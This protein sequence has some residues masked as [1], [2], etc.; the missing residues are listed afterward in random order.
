MPKDYKNRAK[1]KGKPKSKS[2][3]LIGLIG[4]VLGAIAVGVLWFN[5][6]NEDYSQEWVGA[7]PDTAPKQKPH[8]AAKPQKSSPQPPKP[9][10]EFYSVLPEMEVVVSDEELAKP[11]EKKQSAIHDNVS[12][13]FVQVA[14]FRRPE[15]ADKLTAELAFLGIEAKV[16]KAKLNERDIRYRVRTG[17]FKGKTALKNGRAELKQHG[18][19]GIVVKSAR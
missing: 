11:V 8:K 16:H 9:Q 3:W 14:S 2:C 18:H 10:Y 1:P 15:D 13:Y 6:S 17:P 12:A 19:D 4:F 7:R 5:S